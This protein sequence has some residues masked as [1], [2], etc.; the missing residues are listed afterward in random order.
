MQLD[1]N[2]L[3]ALDALLE[4][5][6]VTGAADRLHLSAPAMSRTLG[7]IRRATGDQILVRT[8]RT[9]T[10]TP[11]ATAI[12]EQV[13]ALVHQVHGVLSPER[14]VDLATLDRV[15][16]LRWHDSITTAVGAELLGT[17]RAQAPGVRL[18]FLV[19][20]TADTDDLRRGHVDLETSSHEPELP[21]ISRELVG[22]DRLVV[23]VRADH[24]LA[25]QP[26]TPEAYAAAEHITVS[27]RGRLRDPMDDVLEDLGLRREV[28]AAAP[29]TLAAMQLVRRGDFLIVV[30]ERASSSL[31]GDL[32]LTALPMPVEMPAVPLYLA[33]H[34]RYDGD[35]AHVWLRGQALAA[36]R[37]LQ[38]GGA[39]SGA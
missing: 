38:A 3:T 36:L 10:P 4:E 11:H 19:E 24:P 12:R 2:L 23:L 28:V 33:W 13:H 29:T 34:Q 7:R 1:L 30:A 31:V 15:F 20:T 14:A 22:H 8:G 18:R 27:R 26:L 32:G 35:H 6:S 16:T 39:S 37:A 9:M 21:E 25:A 17:V 5:G